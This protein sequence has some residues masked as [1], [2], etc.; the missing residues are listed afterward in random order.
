MLLV[1][2]YAF[3]IINKI[4]MAQKYGSKDKKSRTKQRFVYITLFL[5]FRFANFYMQFRRA[6]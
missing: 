5:T 3:L 4:G 6:Q 2:A 1:I